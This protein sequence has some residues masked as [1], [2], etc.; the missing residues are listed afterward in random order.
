MIALVYEGVQDPDDREFILK[1]YHD[2]K[3]LMYYTANKYCTN[4]HDCEEIVQDTILKLIHK[5]SLLRTL[6]EK[7]LAAY[8]SVAVR[9]TAFSLQRRRTKE[10]KLFVSWMDEMESIP[11]PRM[12]AEDEMIL[13]EK[14]EALLEVWDLLSEEERFLLEGRYIL[15]YTD[16]ELSQELGGKASGIRMRLTRTRRKA[17]SLMLMR[18]EGDDKE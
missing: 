16:H 2:Y 10:E 1:V 5:V 15:R 4:Y 6:E 9:N 17:S 3:R 8:V 7:A 14:K 12:S 13:M 18:I 11:D